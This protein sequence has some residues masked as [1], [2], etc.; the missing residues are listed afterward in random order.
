[1]QSNGRR[2]GEQLFLMIY[3][4][5]IW[6]ANLEIARNRLDIFCF[7]CNEELRDWCLFLI[8]RFVRIFR[9]SGICQKTFLGWLASSSLQSLELTAIFP[10][11]KNIF[12]PFYFGLFRNKISALRVNAHIPARW[13]TFAGTFCTVPIRTSEA[14]IPLN[15]SW[16]ILLFPKS[17]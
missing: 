2:W 13:A 11:H 5:Q 7:K 12:N 17:V 15:L 9:L 1:M 14:H 8:C 10:E 6:F 16:T 3:G 4:P